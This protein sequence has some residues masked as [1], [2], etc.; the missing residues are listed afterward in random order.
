VEALEELRIQYGGTR[1]LQRGLPEAAVATLPTGITLL[2]EVLQGGLPRG[3][4][5][6]L[7]ARGTAGQE[8][9]AASILQQA[10]QGHNAVAW[11]DS[12]GNIPL[13]LLAARGVAVDR[14]LVL[15]PDGP[16]Q[17]L[18]LLRDVMT[19]R[20]I[21][22]T[23]YPLG[24]LAEHELLDRPLAS[25]LPALEQSQGVLVMLLNLAELPGPMFS[26]YASLRLHLVHQ[27]W[28]Y[29]EGRVTGYRTRV[30]VLKNKLG[31]SGLAVDLDLFF[32]EEIS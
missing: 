28:H 26:F 3:R 12:A 29:E 14:L 2:D 6:E 11:I 15:R 9:L 7:V 23:I 25:W 27:A 19:E 10:Q 20:S 24:G 5:T 18:S 4:L 21:T 32:P 22:A 8:T 17:T 1:L 16:E 30:T 31:P 13:D